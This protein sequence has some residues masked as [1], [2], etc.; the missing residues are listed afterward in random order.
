MEVKF[1]ILYVF[2]WLQS[3]GLVGLR[4][5]TYTSQDIRTSICSILAYLEH[6]RYYIANSMTVSFIHN[7]FYAEALGE[8]APLSSTK[9]IV[10]AAYIISILP[11]IMQPCVTKKAA[12]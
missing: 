2:R 8:Q 10:W 5:N 3:L 12:Y 6:N 4:I 9:Y 7:D 11:E 1:A